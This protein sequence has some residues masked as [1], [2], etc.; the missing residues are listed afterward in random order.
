[1]TSEPL[2]SLHLKLKASAPPNDLSLIQ[3]VGSM[4]WRNINDEDIDLACEII[5]RVSADAIV[6][7][8]DCLGEERDSYK[9]A[10]SMIGDMI[11]RSGLPLRSSEFN[12]YYQ[13][14]LSYVSDFDA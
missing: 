9:S 2:S 6:C 10:F 7:A 13:K 11:S 3:E 4:D 12:E 1:M 14:Y 8:G 5:L